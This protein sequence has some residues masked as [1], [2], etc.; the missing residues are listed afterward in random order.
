M[1]DVLERHVFDQLSHCSRIRLGSRHAV[2]LGHA[3]FEHNLVDGVFASSL[4]LLG[5]PPEAVRYAASLVAKTEKDG[6]FSKDR[7][8]KL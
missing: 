1:V 4:L 7:R 3:Y 8:F 6:V 2:R 5:I